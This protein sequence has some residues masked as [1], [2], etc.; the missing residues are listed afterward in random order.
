VGRFHLD[1]LDRGAFPQSGQDGNGRRV[2]QLPERAGLAGR[3]PP[4]GEAADRRDTA[5]PA[6]P[7]L[8]GPEADP[9]IDGHTRAASKLQPSGERV[10][11][12]VQQPRAVDFIRAGIVSHCPIIAASFTQKPGYSQTGRR[13]RPGIQPAEL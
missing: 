8:I 13:R 2:A 9:L 10:A 11:D 3:L 7:F 4:A 6:G 1:R 12:G 5:S